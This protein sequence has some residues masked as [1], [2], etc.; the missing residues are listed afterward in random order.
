M[1]GSV[2][3]KKMNLRQ[4]AVARQQRG[5]HHGGAYFPPWAMR[6]VGIT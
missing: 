2:V 3:R 4:A 5:L 6:D 1:A